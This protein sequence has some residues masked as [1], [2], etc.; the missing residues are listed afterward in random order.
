MDFNLHLPINVKSGKNAVDL[1]SHLLKSFGNTCLIV[2]G[3]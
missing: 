2:T 3:G 1:N